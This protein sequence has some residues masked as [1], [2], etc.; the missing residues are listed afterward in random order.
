MRWLDDVINTVDMNLTNLPQ[1]QKD[2]EVCHAIVHGVAK[3]QTCMTEG[4]NYH[5]SKQLSLDRECSGFYFQI[6]GYTY[7]I[8][9][10]NVFILGGSWPH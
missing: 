5:N 7:I 6:L 8:T 2:R 9:H 10:R 3:S 4:L 1:I